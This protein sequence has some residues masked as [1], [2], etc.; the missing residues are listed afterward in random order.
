L[1]LRD[2][3]VASVVHTIQELPGQRLFQYR[4]PDGELH[5]VH[6]QDVND[7]IREAAGDDFTSK[8]FRTWGATVLAVGLLAEIPVPAA[9]RPR[10]KA[11]NGA[12]DI[13]ARKLRNTRAVCRSGYIHPAVIETWEA[14]TLAAELRAAGP[15]HRALKGLDEEESV[16]LR[17]LSRREADSLK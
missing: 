6:S 9:R 12:I 5:D 4:D 7:Y 2:R 13:V 11:L 14:G 8:H 15:A 17:W 16:V 3:R 10:A 1:R